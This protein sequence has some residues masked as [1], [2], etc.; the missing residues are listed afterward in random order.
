MAIPL[1]I[2]DLLRLSLL[3]CILCRRFVARVV[4]EFAAEEVGLGGYVACVASEQDVIARLDSPGEPHKESTVEDH[5]HCH[6]L[7]DHLSRLVNI[8]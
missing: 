6:P 2:D 5:C 4:G 7:R 8:S 1:N 3:F